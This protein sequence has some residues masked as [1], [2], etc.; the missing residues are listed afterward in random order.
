M[1]L[2]ILED[3]LKVN[4]KWNSTKIT[5]LIAV[6]MMNSISIVIVLMA[7]KYPENKNETP[8]NV[9]ETFAYLVFGLSGV[10]VVNKIAVAASNKINK[11]NL[12]EEE[13]Q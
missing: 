6:I 11:V 3:T 5:W 1:L 10:A 4:G 9:F 12:K 13:E 2:N 7:Y 8:Y